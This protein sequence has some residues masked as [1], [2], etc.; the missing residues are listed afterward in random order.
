[1]SERA[2]HAKPEGEPRE[3]K[4]LEDACLLIDEWEAAY[5]QLRRDYL[6]LSERCQQA[7]WW[8]EHHA[9]M[10]RHLDPFL[11]DD[12]QDARWRAAAPKLYAAIATLRQPQPKRSRF[13]EPEP[14]EHPFG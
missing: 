12:M 11:P 9:D 5:T 2:V 6:R 8:A 10:R 14:E 4:T 3:L 13:D 1:M 7:Q